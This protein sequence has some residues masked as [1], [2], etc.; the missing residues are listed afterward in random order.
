MANKEVAVLVTS[1]GCGR[2]ESTSQGRGKDLGEDV[3]EIKKIDI[4]C[5]V[6]RLIV[7]QRN[8]E[9]SLEN[10]SGQVRWYVPK[11]RT[12]SSI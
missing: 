8:I 12:F 11:W 6:L 1:T 9:I 2:G 7:C 5:L 4:V 10:L 3:V